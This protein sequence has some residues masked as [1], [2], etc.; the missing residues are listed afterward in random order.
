MKEIIALIVFLGL[1]IIFIY[2]AVDKKI[3]VGLT[4]VFLIFSLCTGLLIANFDIVKRLKWK[5]LEIETFER[6]VEQVKNDAI[7]SIKNEVANLTKKAED[8]KAQIESL[9]QASNKLALLL[10][11]IT[12]MQ[13]STKGEFGTE[14][15]KVAEQNISDEINK[16]L[17]VIIPDPQER[18]KWIEE[19]VG[20]LPV[21]KE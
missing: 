19:L 15:V 11:K 9:N 21:R 17:D 5:G 16:I 2:L 10:T 7:E 4:S 18:K 14:R 8:A 3:G 6:Q 1:T 12:W 20:L 13:I